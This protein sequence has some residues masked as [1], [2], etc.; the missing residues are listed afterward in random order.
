MRKLF[1]LLLLI[2]FLFIIK[3]SVPPQPVRIK[4]KV[5][6]EIKIGVMSTATTL[7]FTLSKKCY[8][9]SHNGEFISRNI[10]GSMWEARVVDA[11]PAKPVYVIVFASMSSL[12]N[13]QDL[14]TVISQK[15]YETVILPHRKN[16]SANGKMIVKN[17][18]YRVCLR[19]YFKDKQEAVKYQ[20]TFPEDLNSFIATK[21]LN[22]KG[23]IILKNLKTHQIFESTKSISIKGGEVTLHNVPVGVGY[24][25]EEKVSN[26][27]PET[28]SFTIDREG[29]L[30]VINLV[31]IETYLKGVVPSEMPDG[32]PLEA[33]K[34]QAVAARS[35]ALTKIGRAVHKDDP[36]DLCDQVHCQVYSGVSKRMPSTDR[37][38]E[39]THGMVTQH[40]G[41][42]CD[43]VYSAVC[44]GHTENSHY[45]WGGDYIDYLQGMY[46]SPEP[47]KKFGDLS[48][49]DN[50]REWIDAYPPVFCNTI[51][52]WILPS[53]EY[54]KKYFR[55]EKKISQ[56]LLSKVVSEYSGKNIGEIIDIIPL[57]RGVS[58]RILLLKIVGIRD[59]LIINKELNIRKTLSPETL[60]SSCFYVR[61]IKENN[62][63]MP[64]EFIFKGAGF[65]HGV[66][67]CQTGAAGLA[68]QGANF[69]Q[70]LNH[71]Y[72]NIK[73]KKLY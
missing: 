51:E 34:A 32:F 13:A 72:K 50:V 25:W 24:H 69:K 21:Y 16:I 8:I 48:K 12:S 64:V 46:D 17:R 7:S 28:I 61:K 45:V 60:W 44:G 37:A 62:K 54:S 27:Y 73:I 57:K 68:L 30:V 38:V 5:E 43:A 66:G 33:L 52:E 2:I 63:G 3:C 10:D 70:I 19:K 22:S 15:E 20:E 49:E 4:E 23:R 36:Y 71:Y 53:M 58:G 56:D 40:N 59:E 55:W 39:E 1:K 11:V 31:P 41:Q 47:L 9:I 65:G 14:A 6:P 26:T 29:K 18:L 42:I 67:M 35:E